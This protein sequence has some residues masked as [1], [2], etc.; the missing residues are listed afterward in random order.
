[1]GNTHS[2]TLDAPPPYSELP[3]PKQ[4][5]KFSKLKISVKHFWKRISNE[6]TWKRI[7]KRV[8]K[9]L[10][11]IGKTIG[12]VLLVVLAAAAFVGCI[13]LLAKVEEGSPNWA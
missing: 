2:S 4:I 13:F 9:V 11:C 8:L 10:I 1:M 7:G 3:P 12:T 5:S 6:E